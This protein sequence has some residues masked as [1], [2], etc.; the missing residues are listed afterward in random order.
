M[1]N[2]LEFA[3]K[4]MDKLENNNDEHL[5]KMLYPN[6]YYRQGRLPATNYRSSILY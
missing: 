6:T 4:Y 1:M 5:Q 2:Y 3:L